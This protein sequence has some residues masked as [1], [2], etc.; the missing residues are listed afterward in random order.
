MPRERKGPLFLAPCTSSL[1]IARWRRKAPIRCSRSKVF[2]Q[3]ISIMLDPAKKFPIPRK[4]LF[5]IFSV[6]RRFS[7]HA[8][9]TGQHRWP[10]RTCACSWGHFFWLNP[11]GTRPGSLTVTLFHPNPVIRLE[12]QRFIILNNQFSAVSSFRYGTVYF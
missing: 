10:I 9:H 4:L 7:K 12:F 1:L 6:S 8:D 3:H 11:D 2:N 5:P